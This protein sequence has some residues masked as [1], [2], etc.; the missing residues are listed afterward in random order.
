MTT[1]TAIIGLV[2]LV[3]LALIVGASL[4]GGVAGA[5]WRR[6]AD[7][8]RQRNEERRHLEVLRH[9]VHEEL[10]RLWEEQQAMRDLRQRGPLCARCPLR[11]PPGPPPG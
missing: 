4:D 10:M 1:A 11:S 3:G 9:T 2:V 5:R 6:V 8:R 7:E